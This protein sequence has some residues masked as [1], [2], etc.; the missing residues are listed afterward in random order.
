ME[1][2]EAALI[3]GVNATVC[4][5]GLEKHRHREAIP[6]LALSTKTSH[7]SHMLN[8]MF[9]FQMRSLWVC[10]SGTRKATSWAAPTGGHR[11]ATQGTVLPADCEDFGCWQKAGQAVASMQGWLHSWA[12]V[13][14]P[15]QQADRDALRPPRRAL[16][17][18]VWPFLLLSSLDLPA[19]Q[20]WSFQAN[21]PAHKSL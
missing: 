5:F 10:K 14:T 2:A 7:G 13:H 11:E 3:Q 19:T 1:D 8:W 20:G 15:E 12:P 4:P 17:D 21:S 18:G 6:Q 9:G 16:V